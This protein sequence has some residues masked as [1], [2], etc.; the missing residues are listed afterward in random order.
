MNSMIKLAEEN[1]EASLLKK[2]AAFIASELLLM[3][4]GL[5]KIVSIIA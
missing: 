4:S 2:N 1:V 5:V 3:V